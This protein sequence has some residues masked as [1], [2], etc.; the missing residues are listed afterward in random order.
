VTTQAAL[1][2]DS[3]AA[4]GAHALDVARRANA[5]WCDIRLAL[6]EREELSIRNGE[7]STLEQDEQ[8]GFGVRVLLDGCWGF[9]SGYDLTEA[10][11]AC[12]AG[13]AV[14]LAKSGRRAGPGRHSWAE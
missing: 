11:V 8:S 6:V 4:L 2:F 10:E 14:A 7:V 3:L 9:A 12:V 5:A 1:S 13:V